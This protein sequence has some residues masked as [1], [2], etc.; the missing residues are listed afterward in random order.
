MSGILVGSKKMCERLD[1]FMIEH[2]IKPVIDRVFGW[3]EV[4]NA[5]DYQLTGSH[6]GKIVIKID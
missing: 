6:F 2:K 5:L 3:T 1:A 4:V